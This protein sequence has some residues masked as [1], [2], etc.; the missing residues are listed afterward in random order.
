MDI[1]Q[2]MRDNKYGVQASV[3]STGAPQAAIVGYVVT[4]N[5]ELFFDCISTHRKAINL[6]KNPRFA[7][8]IGE[9]TA[10]Q[11]RTLQLDGI[12]DEPAGADLERLKRL[13]FS[14]FPDGL[15]RQAWPGITYFRV[16][17]TWI[18]FSDYSSQPQ[19]I[20]EFNFPG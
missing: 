2:F 6:R 1:L 10:S 7:F 3:S 9:S 17:P 16:R 14:I 12:A 20:V 11:E 13:Y 19:K 18:R 8:V 15:H 5:F 4:D